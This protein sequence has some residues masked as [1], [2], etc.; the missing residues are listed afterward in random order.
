MEI[1]INGRTPQDAAALSAL[2]EATRNPQR[3][4]L[5]G[6]PSEGLD[7]S[8]DDLARLLDRDHDRNITSQDFLKLVI[9]ADQ[10]I[11][12]SEEYG[13]EFERYTNNEVSL[14]LASPLFGPSFSFPS[15]VSMRTMI[16]PSAALSPSYSLSVIARPL[17]TSSSR[18]A[19]EIA[20]NRVSQEF[21]FGKMR[22]E[23]D[24][25]IAASDKYSDYVPGDQDEQIRRMMGAGAQCRILA[26]GLLG[27][28]C[29]R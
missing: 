2:R 4:G 23:Q 14:R 18:L 20:H 12:L 28:R 13:R 19:N 17:P 9:R 1:T 11:A 10:F 29:V 15:F 6:S 7:F 27:P 8:V 16:E 25:S 3:F 5:E 26:P 24:A 21:G 22:Q